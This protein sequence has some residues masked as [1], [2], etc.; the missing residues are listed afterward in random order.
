MLMDETYERA[1]K[2]VE[3][4]KAQPELLARKHPYGIVAEGRYMGG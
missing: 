4:L 2:V 1:R 3:L